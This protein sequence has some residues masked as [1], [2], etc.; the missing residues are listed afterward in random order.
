VHI[1]TDRVD[2]A[3]KALGSP[4]TLGVPD[5]PKAKKIHQFTTTVIFV[6]LQHHKN[7]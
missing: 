3:H 2:S 1:F 7:V 4:P 5:L 6:F